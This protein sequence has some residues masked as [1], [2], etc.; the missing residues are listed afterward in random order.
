M[1]LASKLLGHSN[2][3]TTQ[4]YVKMADEQLE[5]GVTVL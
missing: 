1:L 4:R 3:A 2:L 5:E